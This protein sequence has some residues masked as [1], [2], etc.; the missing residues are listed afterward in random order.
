M[1]PISDIERQVYTDIYQTYSDKLYGV[2]LH[3]INDRETAEDLLHDSFIV[4]FSSLD[5]TSGKV[6]MM[7]AEGSFEHS[8]NHIW[9]TVKLPYGNGSYSMYILLP[10]ED[11]T[12]SDVI[13]ALDGKTWKM[14]KNTMGTKTFDLKLPAF[15]TETKVRS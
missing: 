3:Y 8:S 13:S 7:H 14:E 4:I 1:A 12:V 9:S 15:E 11:K 10:H 6:K 2:C 5:S